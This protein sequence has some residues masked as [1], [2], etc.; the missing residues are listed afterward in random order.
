MDHLFLVSQIVGA[1][2]GVTPVFV[3][4]LAVGLPL[5]LPIVGG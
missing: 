4:G 1:A 3:S 5:S 2:D